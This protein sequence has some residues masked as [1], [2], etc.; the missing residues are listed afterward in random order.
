[1]PAYIC[2]SVTQEIIACGL[3][4]V[5]VDIGSDLNIDVACVEEALSSST[6]AVIAAHMYGAPAAVADLED[7]CRRKHVFL[8][9]DAAQVLGVEIDGRPPGTFG[10]VG[11]IS[12]SQSK[13]IVA[14]SCNAGGL[15][16]INNPELQ[17]PLRKAW[18]ALPEAKNYWPDICRFFLQEKWNRW[19]E[20]PRYLAAKLHL[21]KNRRAPRQLTK[22][23]N[24]AAA[25]AIEQLTT[26]PHRI[27]GRQRVVEL[28][29][30]AI[31][32]YSKM[33]LPQYAPARYLTRIMIAVP[34]QPNM[35]AV[36]NTLLRAGIQ[37]RAGYPVYGGNNPSSLATA[38]DL[39]PR[40][41]ELP[42][43]STMRKA[44]ID[45]ALDRLNQALVQ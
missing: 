32:Q 29:Y 3:Q 11:M 22:I 44:E 24:L 13:T 39:Q 20:R 27:R 31:S 15:L 38:K 40:L 33:T 19:T 7:L 45:K 9:D 21:R 42:S 34:A 26:V 18:Q 25:L 12:F 43:H 14:G 1:V 41:L 4:C 23:N 30:Q 16:V 28:Y 37:T 36:R 35:A 17:P 10:D 2:P 6:L 8:I 5:S